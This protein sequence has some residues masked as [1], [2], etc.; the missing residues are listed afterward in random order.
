MPPPGVDVAPGDGKRAPDA[1]TPDGSAPD[2]GALDGGGA[3]GE[4]QPV[5]V[6]TGARHTCAVV[7]YEGLASDVTYC[8]GDGQLGQ[9]GRAAPATGLAP[10]ALPAQTSLRDVQASASGDT[11]CG[12]DGASAVVCWGAN[13]FGQCGLA[14]STSSA[15]SRVLSSGTA[16]AARSVHVG[17][18]SACSVV[19]TSVAYALSCWG[20]NAG[21]ELGTGDAPCT[22]ASSAEPIVGEALAVANDAVDVALG[23]AHGCAVL[24]TGKVACWGE[25]DVGQADPGGAAVVSPP[26]EL[27]SSEPVAVAAGDGFSCALVAQGKV[28]C[29]GDNRTG[30]MAEGN[31]A[32]HQG[33]TEAFQGRVATA[34]RAG[35]GFACI[36][37]DGK[38]VCR[39]AG[40][41]GQLGRGVAVPSGAPAEV[42]GIAKAKSFALGG[43]HACAI[44]ETSP[45]RPELRC[46]GDNTAGQVDPSAPST[47]PVLAPRTV[48]F[49]KTPPS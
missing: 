23:R 44:V 24:A 28:L 13:A 20:R 6:A 39:G 16:V 41:R 15:P 9:L 5:A 34:V 42:T 21:C 17:G 30:V 1:S 47:S 8:W 18:G 11:T 27:V 45:G 10:V 22:P 40:D 12:L 26:K 32:V 2:G 46:W 35:A 38:L 25:N 48:P 43:A 14:P 49:P 31:R 37:E 29:W 3:V 33:T 4:P 36:H 7:H 19:T